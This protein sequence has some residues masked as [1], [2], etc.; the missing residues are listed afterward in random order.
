MAEAVAAAMARA[1]VLVTEAGTGTGKT[2]AYL[3]PALLFN[4]KVIISTGTKH[5]QDQIFHRDLPAVRD[6]L[7]L[8]VEVAL[9]KGRANYLCLQRHDHAIGDGRLPPRAA[10][11]DLHKVSQWAGR[12]RRGDIAAVEVIAEV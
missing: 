2:Y 11:A 4:N 6:A 8:P 5:L 9:L 3:V 7:A 1:E 10:I 12:T